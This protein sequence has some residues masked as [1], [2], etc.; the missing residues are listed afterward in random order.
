M[1]L[2]KTLHR[3]L[4][5]IL[6]CICCVVAERAHANGACIVNGVCTN[7]SAANCANL[8]GT[9]I[10]EGTSCNSLGC[11][12]F[13]S[14][15]CYSPHAGTGCIQPACCLAVCELDP[16]CCATQW[17]QICANL[18][19]SACGGCGTPAAGNCFVA[20]GT[21][22]C[23]DQS[24]CAAVCASTPFCCDVQWDQTCVLAATL[25]CAGCG[26]ASPNNCF[27]AAETPGC[28]STGCCASVCPQDPFCCTT[29]WDAICVQAAFTLCGNC[30]NAQAGSCF[31]VN[32][33][34]GCDNAA[35]CAAVCAVDA[36]CCSTT[37]DTACANRA[38]QLCASCGGVASGSCSSPN[39]TP[40]CD[41]EACCTAV[42]AVDPFCC[43]TQ[44]DGLC[45]S[46]ALTLCAGCVSSCV[47]DLN[48]DGVVDGADLGI[49]LNAWNT[50]DPCADLN[51]SGT[52]NGADLGILLNFWGDCIII[53]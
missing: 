31:A 48:G 22:G 3:L 28:G 24:C 14:Q 17:D 1:D 21:P 40:A 25:L 8:G 13:G 9:F 35:C 52:V 19:A 36:F 29:A 16:F 38:N 6:A 18:A 32:G 41:D 26:S 37:W 30:G 50:S 42:C 23:S 10:G 4:P 20:N 53:D 34:V 43:N 7:T 49:L 5:L 46:R 39:G 33:S 44:W 45:A 15:P 27:I 2:I 12:G 51:G 11:G 47:G